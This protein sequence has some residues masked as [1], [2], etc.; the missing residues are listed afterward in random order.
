MTEPDQGIRVISFDGPV[1]DATGL[2]ELLILEDI[3]GKWA[4]D[5]EGDDREGGDVRASELCDMVG[6][7]GLGGFYAILFSL[8]MTIA[9][10]IASHKI[11]QNVLF[12]SEEWERKAANECIAVLKVALAEVIDKTGMNFTLDDPFLSKDS[13]KCFVCVLNDLNAGCVRVLRNYRTRTSKSPRSTILEAVHATLADGV[14][15]P[16]VCIQDEQFISA[17]S[18]FANPSYE[19]MKELPAVFPKGSELACFVN[20]GA[21]RPGVLPITSGGSQEEQTELLRYAEA[22]AQNLVALCGGL[23]PCFFRLSV[24]AGVQ[25]PAQESVEGAI[26]VV[27]SLTVGYLEEEE[28]LMYADAVVDTLAQRHGVVPLARLGSLAA[29]DGKAKLNNQVEAVHD[30]VVHMKKVMDSTIHRIVTTWLSP[31][32]QAAKLDAC[33]RARS[34]STCGWFWD[35][36]DVVKW[37]KVGGIF[38]CHAGMGTGKTIITSHVIETLLHLPDECSV[39]YYYFEFTNLSTLSEESLFRSIVSQLSHTNETISRQLYEQHGN[40]SLQPQLATLHKVLHDFV[41][42]PMRPIYIIVD[43]LDELPAPQ[44]KYVFEA[45]LKLSPLGADGVRVMITSRDELDI[46]QA[47][48]GNVAFDF[49]I[50][51]GMLHHDIAA[52]VDQELAAKKWRSWPKKDAQV[53]RDS[54]IRKADGMFRMVACQIE[55]LN[56]AQT[57]ED[58]QLALVSLP[59]TLGDTYVYILNTIRPEHYTR[60]HTLLCILTAAFK[61]VSIAELSALLA[62]EL[63]DPTDSVNIPVYR[64]GLRYHEPENLIGLGT[65]LVRRT[66]N[67]DNEIVLQ[68]AHAS[69][70]EFLLHDTSHW[71]SL[72]DQLAHVT[73]ARACLALL[74]HNEDPM[75]SS[76]VTDIKYT[77]SHWW[78]H[79]SSNVSSQLLSEQEKLFKSFPWTHTPTG[80]QLRRHRSNKQLKQRLLEPSFGTNSPSGD[81]QVI[82]RS[83]VAV[84][85]PRDVRVSPLVFAAGAGLE[86]LLQCML[87]NRSDWSAK[88]LNSALQMATETGSQPGVFTALIARGGDVNVPTDD[89]NALIQVGAHL[90]FLHVVQ[91]LVEHGADVN[92]QGGRYGSALQ[93]AANAAAQDVVEFLIE[94]GADV[95]M[96]GGPYGSALQAAVA[97]G[98]RDIIELLVTQGA[99]VNKP[100]GLY[101]SALQAAASL[102]ALDIIKFLIEK[103]ADVNIQGGRFYESALRTAASLG[104]HDIVEF[105]VEKGADV[106]LHGYQGP[107]LH[108]AVLKGALNVV[109]YLVEKG[110]HVNTVVEGH[111]TAMDV[112]QKAAEGQRTTWTLDPCISIKYEP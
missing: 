93:A 66:E 50:E 83:R 9:Q 14:H 97:A 51:K 35:H 81:V 71:Y 37:K 80:I 5:H 25:I 2:S 47:L 70:K 100:G 64:E 40:G 43:A 69:V 82:R 32:D 92:T 7:T 27:K 12:S 48:S 103:G 46:H 99:D 31:I 106:N 39:A 38:W 112:A 102:E 96:D 30:H 59:A 110:A 49:A 91:V 29:N 101:G 111:G 89:G 105:L 52:F 72:D 54:L 63:G 13:L 67:Q 62:V 28:V 15:L 34:S 53:M 1:L 21:G 88:D 90:G 95:N 19:I 41:T 61:P 77:L 94:K 22:V 107:A 60:A 56:R 108:A 65:A 23:G 87:A 20:L 58:M 17:S 10:V 44:R 16:P 75:Q 24:A 45:L 85:R 109:E 42:Q 73:T 84:K 33:I 8:N 68:F 104:A 18:G 76:P 36:P 78:I 3:A 11:L 79:V 86:Q 74:I 4:W 6:G 98:A 55:V 26:R 57:T